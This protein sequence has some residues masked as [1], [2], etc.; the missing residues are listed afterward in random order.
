MLLLGRPG[1]GKSE[2]AKRV[3]GE[4][5][6]NNAFYHREAGNLTPLALYLDAYHHRGQPLLLD[7]VVDDFLGPNAGVGRRILLGLGSS[8][9]FKQVS[10]GTTSSRLGDVPSVYWTSSPLLI[11]RNRTDVDDACLSRAVTVFFDPPNAEIHRYTATWFW[12]QE[13]HDWF[14][15]NISALGPIDVR[16]LVEAASHKRGHLD[17]RHLIMTAH[18][19]DPALAAVIRLEM[20]STC[21]TVGE[22]ARR[23]RE[24]ME[25]HNARGGG[26]RAVAS[27]ASYHRLRRE[28]RA[29][30]ALERAEAI[31]PM[32]LTGQPP[33]KPSHEE[34]IALDG[35]SSLPPE[36][37]A[38]APAPVSAAKAAFQAPVVGQAQQA[39]RFTV[40]DSV[41]GE[42]PEPHI[43][44]D[45]HDDA[46]PPA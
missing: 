12:D 42:L 2:E 5:R 9:A 3:V 44:A 16:W 19:I 13:I 24:E 25:Q 17:W 38:A 22:R 8:G 36:M 39:R 34:L 28:L 45:P 6:G 15:R 43:L 20:D 7:D 10:Y 32:R 31:G 11:I 27:R 18:G 4:V 29:A 30:G 21:S 40:D 1:T 35:V 26:Q 33:R 14:G 23:F 46:D 41:A 37:L